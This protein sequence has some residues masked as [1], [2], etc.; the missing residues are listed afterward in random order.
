MAKRASGYLLCHRKSMSEEDRFWLSEPFTRWQARWDL[1]QM[2]VF[3]PVDRLIGNQL[4]HQER[5]QVLVSERFLAKRWKWGNLR[6]RGLIDL[7]IKLGTITVEKSEQK[8]KRL[9]TLVTIVNYD[10]YQIQP[11][12][13]Q[14]ANESA[15]KAGLKAPAKQD[16]KQEE[17]SINKGINKGINETDPRATATGGLAPQGKPD[18]GN[19][20]GKRQRKKTVDPTSHLHPEIVKMWETIYA[21]RRGIEWDWKTGRN[22]RDQKALKELRHKYQG[23]IKKIESLFRYALSDKFWNQERYWKAENVS[24]LWVWDN[25]KIIRERWIEGIDDDS[26]TP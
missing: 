12:N 20:N 25:L 13:E 3:K 16:Q 14:S 17:L 5:G 6:V 19:G 1:I 18:N 15:S 10:S 21:E 26:P 2:A 7:L 11:L 4:I 23:D 22:P 8:T 24:P 9:G